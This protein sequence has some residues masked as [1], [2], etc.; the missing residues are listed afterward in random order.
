[1]MRRAAIG[2][3]AV[4]LAAPVMAQPPAGQR[5]EA[6]AGRGGRGRGGPPSPEVS[7][8]GRITLRLNAPDA[9]QVIVNGELDG[10]PH[11]MTKGPDGIWTVTIGPLPPDIYTY[12]FNVDG[13]VALDP[14]NTNTKMGY[15]GFGPTSIVQVPG[16]GPQ[17]YDVKPVPHGMVSI[18]PYWSKT[19]G[20][21]RTAWVYTP[22][23]Y[24]KGRNYPVLYLMH[25]AG[26]IESG[27]TLVGRANNILDNLIAEGKTKP[28]V[29]VMPLIHTIQSFYAGPAKTGTVPAP[30]STPPGSLSAFGHD[31][32]DDLLPLVEKTFKVSTKPEDR[33]IGGLSAGGGATINVAFNRPELFRYVVLMSPAAGQN[34]ETAYAE[35]LG[36]ADFFNKQFKLFWMGVGRD[37]TLTGPG[38]KVFD[39]VLTKAGINHEFV[40][41]DGRHEWTVWRHQ[42]YEIAP[43][44][45]R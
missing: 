41:R 43:R 45:F 5:G 6:R 32:L 36:R 37:D 1:M 9:Q 10:Q 28:M 20:V 34:S 27:W 19:L 31:L 12:T 4:M 30:G 18:L 33:A 15:G 21:A 40:L 14:R 42:L 39:Q 25:G 3:L 35:A 13:I 23:G 24:D 17:F 16:D 7:A 44:L 22:P 8:D 11:P 29:V 38:D 26:D 2:I